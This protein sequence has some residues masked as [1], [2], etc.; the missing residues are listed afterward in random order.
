MDL[1]NFI[2]SGTAVL[3]VVWMVLGVFTLLHLSASPTICRAGLFAALSV[4]FVGWLLNGATVQHLEVSVLPSA[5]AEAMRWSKLGLAAWLVGCVFY[6]IRLA[7]GIFAVW[8]MRE[9]AVCLDPGLEQSMQGVV[10]VRWRRAVR[11]HPALTSPCVIG[12]WQPLLL[13]PTACRDWTPTMLR[14]ALLHEVEHLERGDVWWRVLEQGVLAVWW[15]N[16][17]ARW[18]VQ[19]S[20][21]MSEFACDQ[22]VLKSGEDAAEYVRS[23]LALVCPVS[24]PATVLGFALGK[25]SSLRQRVRRMLV[26]KSMTDSPRWIVIAVVL[27]I[28]SASAMAALTRWSLRATALSPVVEAER[29]VLTR[30]DANPFPAAIR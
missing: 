29:E 25:E 9:S 19:Q 3:L 15:W 24:H 6:V 20:H 30:L 26:T 2:L 23:L 10:P 8:Q 5:G 12:W 27:F 21:A 4:P 22:A 18:L 1:L 28:G 11:L 16:P 14:A 13:L 17:L 7:R